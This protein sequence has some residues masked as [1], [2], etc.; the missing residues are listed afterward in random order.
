MIYSV[1]NRQYVAVAQ[2]NIDGN[3]EVVE[4]DNA[5]QIERNDE[6]RVANYANRPQTRQSS[7]SFFAIFYER[8]VRR[9]YYRQFNRSATNLVRRLSQSRLFLNSSR[10]QNAAYRQNTARRQRTESTNANI[11]PESNVMFDDADQITDVELTPHEIISDDTVYR[12][13]ASVHSLNISNDN[14]QNAS[15]NRLSAIRSVA[16]ESDLYGSV[17]SETP[18]PPYNVVAHIS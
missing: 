6:T 7:S 2:R 14:N 15:E 17:R 5:M 12:V 8:P 4:S 16:S 3:N 1:G 10:A 18:P 11:E 13:H 9:R